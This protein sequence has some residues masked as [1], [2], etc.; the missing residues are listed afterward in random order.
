MSPEF[1]RLV[2]VIGALMLFLGLGG[3]LVG[4]REGGKA[5]ALYLAMHGIGL[6]A[7]LVAGIGFAHKSGLGFPNWMIAKLGCW[8]V[9]AAIPIL[10]RKGV[11]IRSAA[12]VLVLALGAAA[13]WLATQPF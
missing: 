11:L 13:A 2:H 10:V 12:I 4:G 6:V 5:P 8:V 7:M 9:L 1:Y 3:V